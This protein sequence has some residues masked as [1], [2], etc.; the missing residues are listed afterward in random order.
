MIGQWNR[1][2]GDLWKYCYVLGGAQWELEFSEQ[3]VE[4]QRNLEPVIPGK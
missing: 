3:T 2:D 4:D 1:K